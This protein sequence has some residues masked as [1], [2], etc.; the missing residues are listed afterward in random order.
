MVDTAREDQKRTPNNPN[1]F[2]F[3]LFAVL[4][5]FYSQVLF[6]VASW[7]LSSGIEISDIDTGYH[8]SAAMYYFSIIVLY[9]SAA[10]L[11]VILYFVE[12]EAKRLAAACVILP[13][14]ALHI[15]R[16]LI[17]AHH[18]VTYYY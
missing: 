9:V 15:A 6:R 1:R 7:M 13:I 14:A 5:L 11:L 16:I 17:T 2:A 12:N 8:L 4:Y 18:P 10:I 3:V